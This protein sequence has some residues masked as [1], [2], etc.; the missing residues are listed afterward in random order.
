MLLSPLQL[1]LGDLSII[2]NLSW[3]LQVFRNGPQTDHSVCF[4]SC[5]FIGTNPS[6]CSLCMMVIIQLRTSVEV[7]IRFYGPDRLYSPRP[8]T[9]VH[10]CFVPWYNRFNLADMNVFK[11]FCELFIC[12]ERAFNT[13]TAVCQVLV[14]ISSDILC[15]TLIQF[16]VIFS[17]HT[18]PN[19]A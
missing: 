9:E 19:L 2:W 11:N 6:M 12:P 14:S 18:L 8:K 4:I 5:L 13:C 16:R 7:N 15:Q 17:W 1:G 10:N 3:C